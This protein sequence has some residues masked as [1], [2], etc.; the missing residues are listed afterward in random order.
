M[1][2][3]RHD[4]H[5]KPDARAEGDHTTFRPG[6]TGGVQDGHYETWKDK[7]DGRHPKDPHRWESVKR[8]DGSGNPHGG[9]PTPHVKEGKSKTVNPA[10]PE[11]IP[12]K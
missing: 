4:N 10:R 12:N 2:S 1:E 3:R 8:Y 9:I 11:E 7:G 5:L 6:S